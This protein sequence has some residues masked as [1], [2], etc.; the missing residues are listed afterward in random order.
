MARGQVVAQSHDT[1]GNLMGRSHTNPIFDTR[2]YEIKFSRGE[3]PELTANVIV[4]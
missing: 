3:V 4:E 1:N 2:M